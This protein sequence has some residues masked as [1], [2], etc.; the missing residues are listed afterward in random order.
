MVLEVLSSS[1]WI[2]RQNESGGAVTGQERVR[3]GLGGH[4]PQLSHV[5]PF[6]LQSES[7]NISP[8]QCSR[9]LQN[10]QHVSVQV[11]KQQTFPQCGL[12]T[13]SNRTLSPPARLVKDLT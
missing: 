7:S 13:N 5:V 2:F 12:V 8:L 6:S 11:K 9:Q 1:H 3:A 10:I 4:T